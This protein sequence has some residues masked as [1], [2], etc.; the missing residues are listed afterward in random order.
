ME[1]ECIN[2]FKAIMNNK[3]GLDMIATNDDIVKTIA[4]CLGSQQSEPKTRMKVLELLSVVCMIDCGHRTCMRAMTNYQTIKREKSR[5]F[6]LVEGLKNPNFAP[7]LKSAYLSFINA[8]VNSPSDID[9]RICI[10]NEFFS[11]GNSADS[12]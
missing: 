10:R 7:N 6:D 3:A 5:F 2:C 1:D 11:I 4:L 12:R 8:L 9:F